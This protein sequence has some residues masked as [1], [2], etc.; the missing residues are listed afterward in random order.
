MN[1]SIKEIA[2]IIHEEATIPLSAPIQYIT[3][4]SRSI[5]FPETTLFVALTTAR[6]DGHR[7]I[8]ACYRKGVRAFIIDTQ[9]E[10]PAQMEDAGFI[11]TTDPLKALQMLAAHHRLQ[12]DI[13]VI[14]ITGSNGKTIVKEW[15]YQLLHADKRITRSPRSYNSQIGVPLSLLMLDR[16]C[17]LGIFEAGISQPKEMQ[18]LETIIKP[19]MGIL[20]NIGEAHQENFSSLQEKCIEKCRLFEHAEKLIYCS[21]NI[22]INRAIGMLKLSCRPMGWSTTNRDA[23]LYIADIKKESRNTIIRY[24]YRQKATEEIIIPFT[25]D[26]SIENAIHCLAVLLLEAIPAT[27]I[28]RRFTLLEPVAM[29]LEVKEGINRC[30]LIDDSYNSDLKSLEIALDFQQRRMAAPQKKKIVILSDIRQSGLLGEVLYEKVVQLLK[31]KE[32][33]L[34]IGIG[35]ELQAQAA[36]FDIE[37]CFYESTDQFIQS[38]KAQTFTDAIILIKG[39]RLFHFEKILEVLSFKVHETILEVNLNHLTDN[40]N[41]YRSLLKP[42]TKTVA[43]VKADAYG[44]GAH[45]IAKSLQAQHCDYLAVAVAD[46]G[47]AL[48]KAGIFIPIMIMNPEMGSFNTLFEHKLEPEVYSFRLLKALI[49][50]AQRLGI[51]RY[52]VHLKLDTGMHRLGFTLNEVPEVIDLFKAQDALM[53][54]SVFS[55]FAGSDATRFDD[56]SQKQL[57]I[58]K[59]ASGRLQ[60]AFDHKILRHILNTAGIE[61]F[62]CEQMEMVR[63]GIGLYG[64]SPAEKPNP[65]LKPVS[66]LRTT[67]LQ[68]KALSAEETV[69]YSRKGTLSRPSRIAAIPIGYADG[70]NRHLGNRKGEVW[71]KGKLVPIV[72]NICMDVTMIDV[73]DT[74]AQEGDPVVIFGEEI[75]VTSLAEKLETIPYEI[76][77]SVSPRV[78]RIYYQE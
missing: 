26:A 61:R 20:T 76:L 54:R 58:F 45:E 21:D 78:K 34:L 70:L 31:G 37:A 51:N 7:Y 3:T 68:I 55:H 27:E 15:L 77:T 9:H 22:L 29:R 41:Y 1:Y 71:V 50:T 16:D 63:L 59:E 23:F 49:D 8:E 65:Q 42:D 66:S 44:A 62:T 72:G 2:T 60:S 52:P 5:S 64:V 38:G 43:M 24:Q 4:D 32:I 47:V 74:D 48:R 35:T 12:F 75:P 36:L 39:A 14:G 57:D 25:D 73:T 40:F 33:D 56:F 10:I 53:I 17:Q 28:A 19:T 13:P 6:N 69:G 11:Q 46:E 30:L 67:I 18:R